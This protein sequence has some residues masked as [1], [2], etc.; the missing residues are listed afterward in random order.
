MRIVQVANFVTPTSGGLRTAL[1]HLAAGY[2]A[3][4]HE[5]VQVVPGE[6]AAVVDTAG[7]RRV[8]LPGPAV[9]GTGYRVHASPR[10]VVRALE[11]LTPD[12]L[13]VHDRTTLRGL[14][15]WAGR[16]GVPALVVSHERLDRWLRQWLPSRPAVHRWGDALADRSNAALAAA[17]GTVVCTTAWAAEE[18]TRLGVPVSTVPL[19]VDAG[20]FVPD[21]SARLRYAGDGAV[22]LA[23]ATR[24]SRE[25]RPH[26]AVAALAELRRRGV[27]AELVVAGDGPARGALQRR[28]AGLP[29]RLLG[30][31]RD[32]PA[33]AGL[34]GAADV[35]LAPGP[36][37]TFGLAALEALACG[38]PVVVHRD[39]ALPSVVGAAGVAAGGTAAQMADAVESL[40]A[41]GEA[42]RRDRARLRAEQFPW[43]RTVRGFLALH[44]AAGREVAA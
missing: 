27:P 9:P 35:V 33:L 11:D 22:L 43:D 16:S 7:G 4:G 25:K 40:L 10:R 28:S 8:E 31:V 6:R 13:E 42:T 20:A 21:R 41:E 34:L 36:V 44:G 3:A 24:L 2:A 23:T 18:F 32:R 19:G 29:V 37:E 1:G 26:L 30:H 12:R 5:V 39:S 14:G 38:T 15:R 17:F